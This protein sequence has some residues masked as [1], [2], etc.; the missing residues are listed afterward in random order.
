[1]AKYGFDLRPDNYWVFYFKENNRRL[2]GRGNI[3]T[4]KH[5]TKYLNGLDNG[6]VLLALACMIDHY[7]VRGVPNLID[8]KDDSFMY[9]KSGRGYLSDAIGTTLQRLVDELQ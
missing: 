8:V 7:G 3:F 6:M 9:V 1:M 5:L 2:F 4:D